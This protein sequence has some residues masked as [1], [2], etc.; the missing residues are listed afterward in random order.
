MFASSLY[1]RSP[2][3]NHHWTGEYGHIWSMFVQPPCSTSRTKT[4][5]AEVG[6]FNF[7]NYLFLFL[8]AIGCAEVPLDNK[9]CQIFWDKKN[10]AK[11]MGFYIFTVGIY[12]YIFVWFGC[13]FFWGG[14]GAG[15]QAKRRQGVLKG[16]RIC[17]YIYICMDVCMHAC[18]QTLLYTER[19]YMFVSI[20]K[21]LRLTI[22]LRSITEKQDTVHNISHKLRYCATRS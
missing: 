8:A 13:V 16:A 22:W 6:D 11:S 17:A 9:I 4:T 5:S 2:W 12:K 18:V 10:L 19:L 3:V 7:P 20:H 15:C 14:G 1:N 21:S